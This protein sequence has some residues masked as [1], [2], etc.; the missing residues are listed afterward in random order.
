MGAVRQGEVVGAAEGGGVFQ[1]ENAHPNR[2]GLAVGA[3][4]KPGNR[5]EVQLDRSG[6]R[7]L[8]GRRFGFDG[9]IGTRRQQQR[10]G[11]CE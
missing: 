4:V 11:D 8:L 1:L 10:G 2:R 7:L 6:I 9:V 3:G 5:M